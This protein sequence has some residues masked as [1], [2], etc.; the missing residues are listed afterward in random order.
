M[1]TS[2]YCGR[3][4]QDLGWSEI[5]NARRWIGIDLE[6]GDLV[7]LGHAALKIGKHCHLTFVENWVV[8]TGFSR[9]IGMSR[10][11]SML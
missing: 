2:V 3:N 8:L 9:G 7:R 5:G 6:I 4:H 1:K 11:A 10:H